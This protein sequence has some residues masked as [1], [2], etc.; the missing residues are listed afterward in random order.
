MGLLKDKLKVL[1][2]SNLYYNKYKY[3]VKLEKI[4]GAWFIH[5]I[6]TV[7]SLT[8]KQ[9][10]DWWANLIDNDVSRLKLT[11]LV[12]FKENHG[13]ETTMRIEGSNVS[14]FSNNLEILKKLEENFIIR[15]FYEINHIPKVKFFTKPPKFKF[16]TYFKITKGVDNSNLFEYLK[17]QKALGL[18]EYNKFIDRP[19]K[20]IWQLPVLFVDYND[21]KIITF[22]SLLHGEKLGKTFKLEWIGDKDKY[23]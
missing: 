7:E 22:L 17:R 10:N 3:K 16:R 14:V 1:H 21:E 13:Q 8:Y 15:Q 18:V 19:K 6:N 4:K 23:I 12:I 20:T 11:N 9:E 5:G 2:Q